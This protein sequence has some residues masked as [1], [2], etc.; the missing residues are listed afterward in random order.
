VSVLSVK[1]W[2]GNL[3]NSL[4]DLHL[5]SCADVTLIS[6]EYYNSLK[7]SPPIQQGMH[8]QLWQ[9]MDT[10]SKLR[11]F[12]RIPIFMMTEGGTIIESEAEAYVVPGMTVPILLGEDYQLTYEVGVTRNVEEGPQ[13]HFGKSEYV[14]A[15]R[16]VD[17]TRDFDHMRQ[18]AYSVGRFIR[19]KLHCRWK[20]KW[21]RQKM[22]F[23]L[24]EKVVRAKED[25]R[26]RPHECKSIQVEGQLGEDCDWLVTKNLLSG[27][28]NSYFAIP[29]TLISANNPWVPVSNPSDHP[30]FIWK[31]EIIGVLSDP[32]EYFD[33][34]KTMADWETR[35]RH[36][37]AITATIQIQI[38]ADR[39]AQEQKDAEP[40]VGENTQPQEEEA[41]S[42]KTAEMLD[43]T[44]YPSS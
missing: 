11:G 18:S 38:D 22:K 34:V 35:T 7:A 27:A 17:R 29:N 31:G 3:D 40:P 42:P 14:I 12:M 37:D 41:F 24:G 25:Y 43:M 39:K 20:N 1:G 2:V 33:H 6:A 16:Q 44:E 32:A 13:V 21:H 15:A 28:D 10:D 5:D 19:S 26:L 9:L 30:R 8:M 4:M 36:A 23:N